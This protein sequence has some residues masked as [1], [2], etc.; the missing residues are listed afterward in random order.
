VTNS[1]ALLA[2]RRS[3][4]NIH[5]EEQAIILVSAAMEAEFEL[6]PTMNMH[7]KVNQHFNLL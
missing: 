4:K 5:E 6:L 2:R 3:A 1:G 7:M